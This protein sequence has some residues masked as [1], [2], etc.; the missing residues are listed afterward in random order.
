[1]KDR[2]VSEHT[3]A[4]VVPIRPAPP[5]DRE[6]TI[7][8]LAGQRHVAAELGIK[9]LVASNE[10]LYQRD[11]HLVRCV[12]IPAKS[13]TGHIAFVP[14]I[15]PITPSILSGALG[16]SATW[17]RFNQRGE[18]RVSDPPDEVTT[19]IMDMRGEWPFPPLA[20]VISTPTL[21]PDGTILSEPGYDETTGLFLINP[22]KLPPIP[23][24][25]TFQDA[26]DALGF[27]N[28]LLDEFPFAIEEGGISISRSV[29]LSMILTA[30][31]R[32]AIGPAV[33]MH[34]IT[35]P[36]PGTGKS[37][38]ADIA[39]AIAT[40][41][42]CPVV[43]NAPNSDETEKRLIGAALAGF[44]IICLD[45][46]NDILTGDFLAQVTERPLLNLRALGSSNM[47]RVANT[48]TFFA[49]GNNITATADMVR[50][51]LRCALDS[52]S[53]NP[54]E[55][56][57]TKNPVKTV[58]ADRGTYVAACLTIARAYIA[59]GRPNKRPPLPSFEPWSDLVRSALV[60]LS[61]PDPVQSM[62]LAR[63]EDPTRQERATF[64]EAWKTEVGSSSK[65]KTSD[66]IELATQ[67]G[68][69]RPLHPLLHQTIH[70]I[71]ANKSNGTMSPDVLGKWLRRN[72]N[73]I[74]NGLKLTQDRSDAKRPKW[75]LIPVPVEE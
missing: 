58:L 49:N 59:A 47:I 50:R 73:T 24:R 3:S 20:G 5:I 39:S 74:S 46:I 71:C 13:A 37:Y 56:T 53:E 11:G 25:P 15:V 17:I 2:P 72:L 38:L 34:V 55:R 6:K 75:A 62:D 57:F 18:P 42:R 35:A 54:E 65:L 28:D 69:N 44:P 43:A 40:G 27:L 16:R 32:G 45:N 21:R 30:V 26:S 8:V 41:D 60:W 36:Q 10:Q 66:I 33:P 22:P 61:W 23:E 14:A 9:A 7:S 70:S 63:A 19:L 67:W 48:F 52:N 64:F 1:M 29:A 31:L 51:T 12:V 4:P 68:E